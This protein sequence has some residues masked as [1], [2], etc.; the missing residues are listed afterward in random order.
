[1]MVLN[2]WHCSYLCLSTSVLREEKLAKSA[3]SFVV[4]MAVALSR[5]R[6]NPSPQ[7]KMCTMKSLNALGYLAE[8]L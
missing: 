4:V 7:C 3:H 8:P 2:F 5:V 6:P 1:M